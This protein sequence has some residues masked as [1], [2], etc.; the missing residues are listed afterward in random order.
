MRTTRLSLAQLPADDGNQTN[1]SSKAKALC[2]V[3]REGSRGTAAPGSERFLCS[4]GVVV[5]GRTLF[6]HGEQ[7]GIRSR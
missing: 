6:G 7:V 2:H 3:A 1:S 5:Q 4:V